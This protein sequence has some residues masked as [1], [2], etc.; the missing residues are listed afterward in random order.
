MDKNLLL[1]KLQMAIKKL[2]FIFLFLFALFIIA[3]LFI[4]FARLYH[5]GFSLKMFHE[6]LD[7]AQK[8]FT[9]PWHLFEVYGFW[10][11]A[12]FSAWQKNKLSLP[13]L[14]PAG[15]PILL[16]A[17]LLY[18]IKQFT[19]KKHKIL[20]PRFNKPQEKSNKSL[21]DKICGE[22]SVFLGKNEGKFLQ[23]K[24]DFS[25]FL[26]GDDGASK[27]NAVLIPT[28]L[29]VDQCSLLVVSNDNRMAKYTSGYRAKLG[30]TFYFNWTLQDEPLKNEFYPRWN[31]LS[32]TEVP[33]KGELRDKY[34]AALAKYIIL[35]G[36]D[37]EKNAVSGMAVKVFWALLEF[38]IAKVERAAAN[39]YFLSVLLEKHHLSKEDRELLLSYYVI[40]DK[41][42]AQPAIESIENGSFDMEAYLPVGSW[43]GVPQD[44]Q[45]KELNFAMFAD[46]LLQSFLA[47]KSQKKS[48]SG[49]G[50]IIVDFCRQEAKFFGYP[51]VVIEKMK[52]I[53]TFQDQ[54]YDLIFP[55][56]FNVLSVFRNSAVRERTA[57]CDFHM[58]EA[59]GYKDPET[60]KWQVTTVYC[61]DA[62]K[63]VNFINKLF[64]D[65][66][67][68]RL[69]AEKNSDNPFSALVVVDGVDMQPKYEILP[70]AMQRT[71][72]SE[73]TFLLNVNNMAHLSSKYGQLELENMIN[74][75]EIKIL[76]LQDT[77]KALPEVN[78]LVW[79]G[80]IPPLDKKGQKSC[81]M[82]KIV[83]AAEFRKAAQILQDEKQ[84]AKL[85][86]SLLL[87]APRFY[88]KYQ[89]I[90][91]VSFLEEDV[92]KRKIMFG[93]NYF[94]PDDLAKKRSASDVEIPSLLQ[95]FQ[96]QGYHLENEDDINIYLENEYDEVLATE[97]EILPPKQKLENK[98]EK[99]DWWLQED[100]FESQK[101]EQELNPFQKK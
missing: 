37:Q 39:D 31:P 68:D 21:W 22:N 11:K 17:F 9:N 90:V 85:S 26:C 49:I 100:S 81:P 93:A 14:L 47:I 52:V 20:L 38:F 42:Y 98:L 23:A 16:L 32:K 77:Q 83:G 54:Y 46:W 28:I 78:A 41:K 72:K 10:I 91:P 84:A 61:V 55:L 97:A 53:E 57:T 80:K 25:V 50:K 101:N 24:K 64:V 62:D 66:M 65:R 19:K 70:A 95:V 45:G 29:S 30:K 67:L 60:G 2:F 18:K 7:F 73:T 75:T 99:G 3:A 33:P 51:Q 79:G 13:M 92:F 44:W 12:V 36:Q 82:S 94:L 35:F 43:E 56:L 96:H 40:M 58:S 27:I 4:A 34:F 5:K 15:F 6:A 48:L 88:K 71:E 89:K 74:Q 8:I 76:A 1:H 69:S 87:F 63:N 59:R 86:E